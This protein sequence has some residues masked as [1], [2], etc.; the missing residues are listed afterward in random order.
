MKKSEFIQ[1]VCNEINTIKERA[2]KKEI[3]RLNFDKFEHTH[4]GHCIYGQMTGD[5]GSK[6]ANQL[7]MKSL[8][9]ISKPSAYANTDENGN[10]VYTFKDLD[11]ERG[12]NFT[13]LESYLFTCSRKTQKEIIEYL[14]GESTELY[15]K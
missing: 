12:N 14:K 6:R 9:E 2:T 1:E 5:C 8:D 11:L 4:S 13:Y 3:D 7:Y 15:I 10:D